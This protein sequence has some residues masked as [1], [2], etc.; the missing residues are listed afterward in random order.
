MSSGWT[1]SHFVNNEC[2]LLKRDCEPGCKGCT[3]YG[4]FVFADPNSDSNKAIER[5]EKKKKDI[6][7]KSGF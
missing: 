3:L 1:C 5:R 7:A 6:D 4:K 2:V